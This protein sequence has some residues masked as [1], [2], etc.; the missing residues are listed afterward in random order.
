[1]HNHARVCMYRSHTWVAHSPIGQWMV[2]L[3]RVIG[4]PSAFHSHQFSHSVFASIHFVPIRF[5]GQFLHAFISLRWLRWKF[6][7]LCSCILHAQVSRLNYFQPDNRTVR[8]W[9][10]DFHPKTTKDKTNYE[11]K[12]IRQWTSA[13][14]ECIGMCLGVCERL[15]LSHSM[16]VCGDKN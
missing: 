4:F 14:G 11:R 2:L 16:C 5:N 7:C 8:R 12:S 10:R 3:M 1:M 6:N 15:S 9:V 13:L